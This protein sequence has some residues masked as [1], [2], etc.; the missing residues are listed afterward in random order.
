MQSPGG[1]FCRICYDGMNEEALVNP[2]RC[3]GSIGL[4]HRS[5]LEKWL[6]TANKDKCDLC[7]YQFH[8]RRKQRTFIQWIRS[9]TQATSVRTF[10]IDLAAISLLTIMAVVAN[11]YCITS[12]ISFIQEELYF[13]AVALLFICAVLDSVHL[14]WVLLSIRYHCGVVMRW[15]CRASVIELLNV[16]RRTPMKATVHVAPTDIVIQRCTPPVAENGEIT[17]A[18]IPDV[19]NPIVTPS[20]S[21]ESDS[22]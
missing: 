15:R 20:V 9:P 10:F 13:E 8:V 1:P 5:C 4:I 22:V 17:L 7:K 19:D 11:Y 21:V 2:C 3:A 12:G 14:L 16:K 18:V 6:V